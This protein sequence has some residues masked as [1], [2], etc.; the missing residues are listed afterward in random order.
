MMHY[1]RMF[2]HNKFLVEDIEMKNTSFKLENRQEV[3]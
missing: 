1:Q 3:L 2:A